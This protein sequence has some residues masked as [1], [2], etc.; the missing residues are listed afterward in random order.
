VTELQLAIRRLISDPTSVCAEGGIDP[1]LVDDLI[2]FYGVDVVY[3]NTLKDLDAATRSF[4]TQIQVEG[5]LNS[6]LLTGR[7]QFEDV[8]TTLKRLEVPEVAFE[9]RLHVIAASS[10]M[11]HGVDIDRLNVM[12]MLGMPLTTAEFIQ[13]TARVGRKYPRLVLVFHKIARE[14][15]AGVYRSFDKFVSQGDRFVETI[16]VTRRSRRVLDKTLAGIV[17]ARILMVHEPASGK[18]LSMVKSLRDYFR[19]NNITAE[20]EALEI[21]S[22]LSLTDQLDEGLRNDLRF[23]M[24]RFFR[25]LENPGDARFPNELCPSGKPMRSLRDVEEQAPI[26]G[27]LS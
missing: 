27:L 14:R 19:S 24:E 6:G 18:A 7:T 23:W 12:L 22:A 9:A 4:E 11:S 16:P 17:M 3:G 10:M 2:S 20:A 5:P 26:I 8:R 25:N 1:L 15:D 13:A 21:I